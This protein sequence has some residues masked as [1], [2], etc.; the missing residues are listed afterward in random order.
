MIINRDLL[1]GFSTNHFEKKDGHYLNKDVFYS[2][3]QLKKKANA[4]GFDLKIASSFRNF[5]RQLIIW[6]EKFSGKRPCLD[7]HEIPVDV[8][9]LS[10][11]KKIFLILNWSAIPGLSRHHWGTDLDVYDNNS[12]Q[13]NALN[14]TLQNYQ[15]GYQKSFSKWLRENIEQ[16]GFYYPY[17]Q[18][19]TDG[20]Q[21]EPWH[22]SHIKTAHNYELSLSLNEVRNF[23]ESDNIHILGKGEILKNIKFIYEN[24]IERHFSTCN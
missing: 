7:E 13:G 17:Y 3:E 14:L 16:F 2:Y 15:K 11:T 9:S 5:E 12:N 4:D 22:I 23:L 8:S 21:M 20:V 1:F 19:L 24:Y 18:D 10:S 6:N